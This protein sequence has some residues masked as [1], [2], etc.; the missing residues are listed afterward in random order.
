[1][2]VPAGALGESGTSGCGRTRRAGR[3]TTHGVK[4]SPGEGNQSLESCRLKLERRGSPSQSHLRSGVLASPH[5]Y[6]TAHR[7]Y[8]YVHMYP[9]SF[10]HQSLLFRNIPLNYD[11]KNMSTRVC[12]RTCHEILLVGRQWRV[13]EGDGGAGVRRS[14]HKR[15][16]EIWCPGKAP[17]SNERAGRERECLRWR[18]VMDGPTKRASRMWCGERC[19]LSGEGRRQPRRSGGSMR[20]AHN[21]RRQNGSI[22]SES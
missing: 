13:A 4:G 6:R 10:H 7:R 14:A 21:V 15:S 8:S 17:P 18:Y 22:D 19:S 2:V 5:L 3:G 20:W 11:Q 16:R 9:V 12:G 1:M